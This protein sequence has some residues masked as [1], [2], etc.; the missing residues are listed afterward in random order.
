MSKFLSIASLSFFLCFIVT[1]DSFAQLTPEMLG[2]LGISHA[3]QRCRYYAELLRECGVQSTNISSDA[4][5][6]NTTIA[7]PF[8]GTTQIDPTQI[9][10]PVIPG[11][12]NDYGSGS[13]I[14]SFCR[15]EIENLF[16]EEVQIVQ[17]N[18]DNNA[19]PG[20]YYWFN[21]QIE[22]N[23]CSLVLGF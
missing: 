14:N 5:G 15:Y 3:N 11:N 13:Y 6:G 22:L 21:Y 4:T 20:I 8:G 19:Y 12:N 10:N 23:T 1:V 7:D 17:D 2:Q 18:I 16:H 9:D